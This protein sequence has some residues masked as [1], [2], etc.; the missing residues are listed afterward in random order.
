MGALIFVRYLCRELHYIWQK[1]A[2]EAASLIYTGRFYP[3]RPVG[4]AEPVLVS[5]ACVH[6][7]RRANTQEF[8]FCRMHDTSTHTNKIKLPLHFQYKEKM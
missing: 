2:V 3:L 1:R 6:T 4:A 8:F 5:V 7:G